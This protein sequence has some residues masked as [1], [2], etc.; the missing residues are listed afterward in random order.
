MG[1]ILG[2]IRNTVVRQLAKHSVIRKTALFCREHTWNRRVEKRL[3]RLGYRRVQVPQHSPKSTARERMRESYS[4]GVFVYEGR[5]SRSHSIP[6]AD[7]V[8]VAL[9]Q[10]NRIQLTGLE[11]GTDTVV[12]TAGDGRY[13]ASSVDEVS[14][15]AARGMFEFAA[16]SSIVASNGVDSKMM[17][18]DDRFA[19]RTVARTLV[20]ER[21]P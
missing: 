11:V 5:E 13:R 21:S 9:V 7:T 17:F 6:D 15:L 2:Y 8:L 4:G 10:N 20:A 12:N 16:S 3:T 1:Y 14:G 19:L 18:F